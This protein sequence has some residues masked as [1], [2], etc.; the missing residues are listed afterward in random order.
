MAPA[1]PKQD[2]GIVNQTIWE[3]LMKKLGVALLAAAFSL[4]V[5]FAANQAPAPKAH[6]AAK[7]VAAHKVV[8]KKHVAKKTHAKA[9]TTAAPKAG[10]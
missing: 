3:E 9:M 10:K 1:L 8:K 7:K 5:A 6:A 2:D 4:P